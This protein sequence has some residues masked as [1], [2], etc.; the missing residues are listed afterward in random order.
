[1]GLSRF[2]KFHHFLKRKKKENMI[3]GKVYFM[4]GIRKLRWGQN[5]RKN[6]KENNIINFNKFFWIKNF[7]IFE[8]QKIKFVKDFLRNIN[9]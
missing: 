3:F 1:M 4:A 6:T 8:G 9:F 7:T 2:L 5:I